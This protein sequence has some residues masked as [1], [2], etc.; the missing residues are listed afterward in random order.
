MFPIKNGLKLV[1]ALSPVLF[2]FALEY[3]IW[4]VHVNQDDLKLNGTHQLLVYAGML[5]GSVHTIKKNT[6]ALVVDCKENGLEVNADE[7]HGIVSRSEFR[8]KA[9]NKIRY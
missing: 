1:N 5:G 2:H 3:E 8:T 9:Q 7:V 4:R 6:G